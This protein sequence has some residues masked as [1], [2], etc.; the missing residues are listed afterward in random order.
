MDTPYPPLIVTLT[1]TPTGSEKA[2]EE[3]KRGSAACFPNVLASHSQPDARAVLV[4]SS[5][6]IF[7][8]QLWS[9]TAQ[10]P[11]A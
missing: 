1:L 9:S 4:R 11:V 7:S 2:P 3:T 10:I 6:K 8:N 5:Y